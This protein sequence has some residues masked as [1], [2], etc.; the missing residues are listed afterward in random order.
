MNGG[1][2]GGGQPWWKHIPR[3]PAVV[4]AAH[5]STGV[6]EILWAPQIRRRNGGIVVLVKAAP[7]HRTG[8]Q[9][10]VWD[11][12]EATGRQVSPTWRIVAARGVHLTQLAIGRDGRRHQMRVGHSPQAAGL[13]RNVPFITVFRPQDDGLVGDPDEPIAIHRLVGEPHAVEPTPS[14]NRGLDR[15]KTVRVDPF[16]DR[17]ELSG[18]RGGFQV[19]VRIDDLGK[20][21]AYAYEVRPD[22]LALG[23]LIRVV[24]T[25]GVTVHVR[26]HESFEHLVAVQTCRV[27]RLRDVPAQ[28]AELP[29]LR[30]AFRPHGVDDLIPSRRTLARIGAIEV[31]ISL[32]PVVGTLYD[33]G[34]LAYASAT[35]RNFW[36]H[37]VG[38]AELAIMGTALSISLIPGARAAT[39]ALR[40]ATRGTS[41]A[42][43]LTD[44][45]IAAIR[46]SIDPDYIAALGTLRAADADRLAT[47]LMRHLA[48]PQVARL[49]TLVQRLNDAIVGVWVQSIERRLLSTVFSQDFAGF[50]HAELAA[51]YQRYRSGR[52]FVNHPER[53]ADPATWAKA[54]TRVKHGRPH[55]LLRKAL[56]DAYVDVINRAIRADRLPATVTATHIRTYD[57]VVGHGVADYGTLRNLVTKR[58]GLAGHF[59][60]DHLLEQRF[61][62][63]NPD[64]VTAF[65]EKGLGMAFLV[66]RNAAVA[67]TMVTRFSS[68]PIR[69]V[70]TL[71]TRGLRELIPNGSEAFF[72]LQEIWDAHVHVLR[73][74]DADPSLFT[75]LAE[76]FELMAEEL[77]QTFKR[78]VPP[79][80]R[81][82]R[83][84]GWP[85]LIRNDDGTWTRVIVG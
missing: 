68:K 58:G 39:K 14:G 67:R 18:H 78:R 62:R 66:P 3:L 77:G 69:Y 29:E 73:T 85:Q 8:V 60:L 41:R 49:A 48:D 82:R 24:H 12:V 11:F 19:T 9:P 61:W 35:G 20:P 32:I 59:E 81:F 45:A 44:D 7:W 42:A 76:D 40:T 52:R 21:A 4:A 47:Q 23:P 22:D 51:L 84:N 25:R 53:A 33:I 5:P 38:N 72:T 26:A 27:T 79:A 36:G 64:L 2:P 15:L 65:D 13:A 55:Q 83:E 63:N 50:Q 37:R 16:E 80:S 17:V 34:Q 28:G 54:Q 57:E 56:G 75:R 46:A 43:A 74:L 10:F 6:G 30:F 71:K 1:P 31:G 70:H